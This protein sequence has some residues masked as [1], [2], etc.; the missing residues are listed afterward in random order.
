MQRSL[1][2]GGMPLLGQL[3]LAFDG[4]GEGWAEAAWNPEALA[5]NPAGIVHGGVYG[6]IHDAAMNFAVNSALESG[7]R[8]TTLDVQYQ[9]MRAAQAGDALRVRGEIVRLTRQVGYVRS[10]VR[11]AEGEVVSEATSTCLLRRRDA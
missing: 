11:N 1:G 3:G 7:D 2:D 9:T 5:C 8:T 6:V 4:Y 10:A